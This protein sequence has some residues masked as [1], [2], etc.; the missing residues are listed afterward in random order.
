ML[1]R[2]LPRYRTDRLWNINVNIVLAD[3]VSTAAT[4]LV[5]ET[6]HTRLTTPLIEVLVTALI[7]GSISLALFAT[8]HYAVGSGVQYMLLEAEVRHGVSVLIAYLTAVAVARTAHTLYGKR[9]GLFR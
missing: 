9:S 8:L 3:V 5:I 6:V 2:L 1:S 7:D 4:A